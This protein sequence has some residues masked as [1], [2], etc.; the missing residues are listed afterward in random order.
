MFPIIRWKVCIF[1]SHVVFSG[2]THLMSLCPTTGHV[3]L[4]T[5]LWWH[6]PSY[7]FFLCK[8]VFWGDIL[9]LWWYSIYIR[10]DSDW[11]TVLSYHD[12]IASRLVS[13][14]SFKLTSV[15]FWYTLHYSLALPYFLALLRC[16]RFISCLP[17]SCSGTDH[18]LRSLGFFEGRMVFR[19]QDTSA[20]C[21]LYNGWPNF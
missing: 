8:L 11:V 13:E 3:I 1:G 6:L 21:V 7:C 2:S 14:H 4:I 15:S 20:R 17:S 10:S 12:Q 9:W 19:N 16:P 18:F 5:W